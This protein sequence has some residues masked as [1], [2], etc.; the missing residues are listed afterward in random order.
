[1]QGESGD[2]NQFIFKLTDGSNPDDPNPI[3]LNGD[4]QD[5]G[6]LPSG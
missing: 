1:V 4:Y 2:S 5:E 6:Y 3:N